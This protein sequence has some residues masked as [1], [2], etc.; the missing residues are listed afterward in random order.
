MFYIR[1][2]KK[3]SEVL[4]GKRSLMKTILYF[5]SEDWYFCHIDCLLHVK[6]WQ[7]GFKV[8]VVTRVD[9]TSRCY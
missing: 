3:L 9:K 5:V 1:N 8:V 7:K 2:F 6:L 4:G